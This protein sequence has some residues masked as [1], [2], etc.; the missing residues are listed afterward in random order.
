MTMRALVVTLIGRPDTKIV[1]HLLIFLLS[2]LK[3]IELQQTMKQ[4][5]KNKI[6]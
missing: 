1:N 3:R 2:I 6:T 4:M 5:N